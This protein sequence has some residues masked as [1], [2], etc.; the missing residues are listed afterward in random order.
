MLFMAIGAGAE[1]PRKKPTVFVGEVPKA[2]KEVRPDVYRLEEN[3]KQIIYIRTPFGVTR[4][5]QSAEMQKL[6]EAGP[7]LGIHA[8]EEG[9]YY[10]FERMT[11]FG[12]AAWK[13]KKD[14]Q[15]KLDLLTKE[16]TDALEYT[17]RLQKPV[18]G[19]N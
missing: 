2:A 17:R 10:K 6:I 8:K 12:R 4:M 5:E 3:G 11:P 1:E 14:S 16:E 9:E 13:K 18:P 19:T 7:P 15:E